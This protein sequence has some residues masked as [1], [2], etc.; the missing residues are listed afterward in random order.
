MDGSVNGGT[1][2]FSHSH[3]SH[4][5]FKAPVAM[6]RPR[7]HCHLTNRICHL[8]LAVKQTAAKPGVSDRNRT[9]FSFLGRNLVN[10]EFFISRVKSRNQSQM[11]CSIF[12][13][14]ISIRPNDGKKNTHFNCI[15]EFL[16]SW[17]TILER[18]LIL[19]RINVL[20]IFMTQPWIDGK[21]AT[22]ERRLRLTD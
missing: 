1:R 10:K 17:K 22:A 18:I 14:Q 3:F 15:L 7:H 6:I 19:Q 21:M 9:D 16:T 4:H 2:G 13:L 5:T 12:H 11:P 8:P 20:L